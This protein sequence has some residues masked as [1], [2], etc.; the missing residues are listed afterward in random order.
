MAPRTTLGRVVC[1]LVGGG[2][3]AGIIAAAPASATPN[4][5]PPS[6]VEVRWLLPPTITSVE[7]AVAMVKRDHAALFQP[8]Q[9]LV[10]GQVLPTCTPQVMQVDQ[11]KPDLEA[12]GE[13]IADKLLTWDKG[14]E[15]AKIYLSH[16]FVVVPAKDCTPPPPPPP[17]PSLPDPPTPPPTPAPPV[18]VTPPAPAP[19]APKPIARMVTKTFQVDVWYLNKSPNLRRLALGA[20]LD[21]KLTRKEAANR[22]L[23]PA[24][25]M[26]H[27]EFVTVRV[28]ATAKPYQVLAAVNRA[29]RKGDVHRIGSLEVSKP[30]VRIAFALGNG[31]TA[32]VP[33]G[34]RGTVAQT[35]FAWA[36]MEK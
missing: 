13:V 3:A 35:V 32:K 2:L 17:P 21:G 1:G 29:T 12:I 30:V 36:A 8:P 33:W 22:A 11:Y 24:V 23:W 26:K 16:K 27:V 25:P 18:A 7:Q 15:D 19:Q 20:L 6:P 4:T 28:P 10:T 31:A 5:D 14:P 9:V 34:K